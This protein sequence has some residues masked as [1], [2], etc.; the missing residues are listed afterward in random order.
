MAGDG[1]EGL[2]G[3]V[4]EVDSGDAQGDVVGVSMSDILSR[5]DTPEVPGRFSL[6]SLFLET[7]WALAWLGGVW[8]EGGSMGRVLEGWERA[9][10]SSGPRILEGAGFGET[11]V[12]GSIALGEAGV[13]GGA[14]LPGA[15]GEVG[16][17]EPVGWL[18]GAR[19]LM[20]FLQ[21][22]GSLALGILFMAVN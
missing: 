13:E 17:S 3:E 14:A 11:K 2:E 19:V 4:S 22:G 8:E 16:A 9:L 6:V 15:C 1:F 12:G 18:G 7:R 5:T 21:G 10:L 20:M